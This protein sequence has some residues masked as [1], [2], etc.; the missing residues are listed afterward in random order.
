M[1]K[2]LLFQGDSV[3]DCGDK[4]VSTDIMMS[5]VVARCCEFIRNELAFFAGR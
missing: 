2:T 4:F 5:P 3:T 1:G